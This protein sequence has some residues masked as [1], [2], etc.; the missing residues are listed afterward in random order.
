MALKVAVMDD[1]LD[2]LMVNALL[3]DAGSVADQEDDRD[4]VDALL[5][6]YGSDGGS[7][8]DPEEAA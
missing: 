2:E 5:Q 3:Q 7:N 8:H 1:G 4:Q 6:E